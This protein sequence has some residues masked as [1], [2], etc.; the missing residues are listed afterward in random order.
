MAIFASAATGASAAAVTRRQTHARTRENA[1]FNGASAAACTAT[2]AADPAA[3][4]DEDEKDEGGVG[5]GGLPPVC[6]RSSALSSTASSGSLIGVAGLV[7]PAGALASVSV[8][9]ATS[10]GMRTEKMGAA[11]P[12]HGRG[13]R[14][15]SDCR[16]RPP[17]L[18]RMRRA[19]GPNGC[20]AGSSCC[21]SASS[22]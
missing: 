16:L 14:M 19:D 12:V 7:A 20:G 3:A 18:P 13:S 2:A 6:S 4:D 22:S 11:V 9:G 21:V 1:S 5:F 10:G 17:S 8:P 15:C